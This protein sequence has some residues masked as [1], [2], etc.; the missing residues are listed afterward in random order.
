MYFLYFYKHFVTQ[1]H[2]FKK[3][4]L[5]EEANTIFL[6]RNSC[7]NLVGSKTLDEV[8]QAITEE[9]VLYTYLFKVS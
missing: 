6:A 4:N 5:N 8:R 2:E 7:N 9:T 3:L 1:V